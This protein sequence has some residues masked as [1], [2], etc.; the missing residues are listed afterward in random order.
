MSESKPKYANFPERELQVAIGENINATTLKTLT[1]LSIGTYEMSFLQQEKGKATNDAARTALNA[2]SKLAKLVPTSEK[3]R[4]FVGHFIAQNEDVIYKLW[5]TTPFELTQS[6]HIIW[7][8][9]SQLTGD[10]KTGVAFKLATAF[11]IDDISNLIKKAHDNAVVLAPG[12]AFTLKGNPPPRFQKK[13]A[14]SEVAAPEAGEVPAAVDPAAVDP[15]AVEE[16]T[17]S[18]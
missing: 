6:G 11:T 9:Y 15:A 10:K 12:E 1:R 13:S 7:V 16:S 17:P 4:D 5:I 14:A 8:R 18:T 2:L 3:T